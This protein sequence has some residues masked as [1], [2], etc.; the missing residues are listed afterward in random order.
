MAV[1]TSIHLNDVRGAASLPG[2]AC[3]PGNVSAP[4]PCSN[5][6]MVVL[7]DVGVGLSIQR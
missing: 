7:W 1:T 4:L 6:Q 5:E 3:R 2:H